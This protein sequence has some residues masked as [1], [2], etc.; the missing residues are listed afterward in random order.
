MENNEKKQHIK[1]CGLCEK[2][3]S[4]IHGDKP[5][6]CPYCQAIQW[7]KPKDECYLFNVQEQYIK[8]KDKKYL[9][10]IYKRL[11]VYGTKMARKMLG[12]SVRL[13]SEILEDRV[14]D[15]VTQFISYYLRRADYYIT[16]SFGYQIQK[17]LQQTLYRKKQQDIDK[18]EISYNNPIKSG[19]EKTFLDKISE[20]FDD[21]N[22]YDNEMFNSTNKNFVI[23]EV[24]KFVDKVFNS[25]AEN[26]GIDQAIL[27]M[28]L[29]H[30]YLN[31]KK[32]G[33]FED[34]YSYYGYDVKEN[35]ELEKIAL[36]EF[37]QELQN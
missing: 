19:E 8:T 33:F 37:L 5:K 30:H 25:I 36:M 32:D 35:F 2:Q 34:F 20:D 12:G 4:W 1:K 15:A 31:K 18:N 6:T 21:G 17:A 29:L 10:D 22:K 27:S 26:R 3:V 9:G 11:L 16:I 13:D 7:D 23:E 24:S 14:Q 28:V